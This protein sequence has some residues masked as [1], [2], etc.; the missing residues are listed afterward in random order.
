M[1][2]KIILTLLIISFIV[3]TAFVDYYSRSRMADRVLDVL[4][5]QRIIDTLKKKLETDNPTLVLEELVILVDRDSR[6]LRECHKI[7]HEIGHAAYRKYHDFV[8][9]ISF[10]DDI[11]GSGYLHGV[12]EEKFSETSDVLTEIKTICA[13]NYDILDLGKCYHGVGHGLMY[14]N[15]NN[16]PESIKWC[17]S[18][19]STSA[20]IRCTE[21][22]YMENF[23]SEAPFHIS[24]YLS[25]N[26]PFYPCDT[27]P[28][29]FKFSC[30]YYAPIYYLN[31]HVNDYKGALR[32]CLTINPE[33]Q[34]TCTKGVGSRI[35][36]QNIKNLSFAQ[37]MCESGTKDQLYPCLE[38]II[39][40]YLVN[41][42]SLEKA[43]EMCSRLKNEYQNYCKQS[44]SKQNLLSIKK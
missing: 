9:A 38:G 30:Y 10:Q 24:N 33:F 35:I 4:E 32:A 27:Q 12:I 18:L 6:V 28:D 16:L 25:P 36:K 17:D 8:Q 31:L 11:C 20:K 15:G 7:V 39:S 29:Q 23:G 26:D 34:S 37:K 14:Y 42:N 13:K 3:L 21:G 22:V 43:T 40:Y 1:K 19:V 2:L 44:I 41:F 5:R